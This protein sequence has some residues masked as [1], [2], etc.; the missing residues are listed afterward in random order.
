VSSIT[1]K[2]GD[3]VKI[4]GLTITAVNCGTLNEGGVQSKT[5]TIDVVDSSKTPEAE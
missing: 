2:V 1:I 5:V 3:S 4:G